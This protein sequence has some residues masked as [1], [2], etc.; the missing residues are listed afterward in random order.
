MV[1]QG[2]I[3]AKRFSL[4]TQMGKGTDPG[5]N[6]RFA[7]VEGVISFQIVFYLPAALASLI[8]S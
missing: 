4:R 7:E 6:L 8:F 5:E 3:A 2:I 1:T